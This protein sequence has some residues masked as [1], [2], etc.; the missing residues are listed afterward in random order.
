MRY[1]ALT[2]T[3]EERGEEEVPANALLVIHHL[4][5]PSQGVRARA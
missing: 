5:A 3:K 1:I 4:M 2:Y